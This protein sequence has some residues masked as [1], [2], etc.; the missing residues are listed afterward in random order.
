MNDRDIIE[1][2]ASFK[3]WEELYDIVA[4]AIDPTEHLGCLLDND[5]AWK[6]LE[7]NWMLEYFEEKE[8]YEKCAVLRDICSAYL[9]LS[10]N[11]QNDLNELLNKMI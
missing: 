7:L 4:S 3:T 1:I 6:R 5:G 2:A 8:D 9:V 11:E 10:K